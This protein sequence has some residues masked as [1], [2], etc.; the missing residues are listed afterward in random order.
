MRKFIKEELE[1]AQDSAHNFNLQDQQALYGKP[2]PCIRI[3]DAFNVCLEAID[4]DRAN[5]AE[6]LVIRQGVSA[7]N[8]IMIL[9]DVKSTYNNDKF[10]EERL[11]SAIKRVKELQLI[12]MIKD[13]LMDFNDAMIDIL[14]EDFDGKKVNAIYDKI[15]NALSV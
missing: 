8:V 4:K 7:A 11:T 13:A 14:P 15:L 1:K 12:D 5:R 9:E 10:I 3:I 6:T 2:Q